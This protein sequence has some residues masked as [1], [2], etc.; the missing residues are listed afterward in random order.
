MTRADLTKAPTDVA[1]M[2]DGVAKRYDLTNDVLAMGQT[3][4]WRKAVV[5]AVAPLPGEQILDLAAG[6]GTSSLPFAEA[7]AEVFPT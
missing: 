3:R 2:F 5:A 4:R 1:A 7:G 6:T